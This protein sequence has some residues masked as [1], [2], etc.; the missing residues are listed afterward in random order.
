[1]RV[2]VRYFG[3]VADMLERRDEVVV[4]ADG[5]T[6]A[7]LVAQLAAADETFTAILGQVSIV[8]DGRTVAR[9]E[10]LS[11]GAEVAVMRPIGGGGGDGARIVHAELPIVPS[12]SGL[13]TQHIVGAAIGATQLFVGQQWLEPGERVFLPTHPCEEALTFLA[14]SGEATLGDDV[15][16]IAAGVSLFIPIGVLHGFRN[17]GTERLHVMVIFPVPHFA[18]TVITEEML[19]NRDWREHRLGA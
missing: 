1:M 6:V 11:D 17:T 9:V 15:V 10:R 5:A 4:I 12:P 7:D 14:G 18:E 3:I 8:I 13:P 16:P 19:G 2:K